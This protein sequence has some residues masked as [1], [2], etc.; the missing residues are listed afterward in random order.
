[1]ASGRV[2]I[3]ALNTRSNWTTRNELGLACIL[4]GRPR[5]Q[6]AMEKRKLDHPKYPEGGERRGKIVLVEKVRS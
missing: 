5:G 4:E 6:W 3:Q 2:S 1:M